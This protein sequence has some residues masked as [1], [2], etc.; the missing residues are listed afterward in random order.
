MSGL[1]GEH[2]AG[3]GAS[4]KRWKGAEHPWKHRPLAWV[5]MRGGSVLYLHQSRRVP[6][7]EGM[8]RKPAGCQG[9]TCAER[10]HFSHSVSRIR[11]SSFKAQGVG[12]SQQGTVHSFPE[13]SLINMNMILLG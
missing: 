4:S 7:G 9:Q 3:S 12:H 6:K 11:S 8:R 10:A 1:V 2:K 13:V 5:R